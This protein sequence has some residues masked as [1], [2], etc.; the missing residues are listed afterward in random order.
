[1]INYG[2]HFIDK[3]DL[4]GVISVLKSDHLTQGKRIDLFEKKLIKKFKCDY[5][6][7]VS[8]GTAAL[9]LSSLALKWKKGDTVICS[10]ITF[11]A[12]ANCILYSAARPLFVDIDIKNF[13]IDLNKIELILKKKKRIKAIIATD[14]AGNPCDWKNL[15]YL[16]RKY[17]FKLVNDNCHAI[18]AKYYGRIDYATQFSDLVCHSYH[19]VKSITTGEG[20]AVLSNNQE[21]ITKIKIL[22]THG[23]LKNFERTKTPWLSKMVE[24]GYNYRLSDISAS[25]GITQLEKIEKFLN[26]RK[27]IA[28]IYFKELKNIC[29]IQ[30]QEI[31]KQNEHAF[32]LFPVLINFKKIKKTR[33]DMFKYFLKNGIVLQVHYLPIYSHFFYKKKF[34][35]MKKD[36]PNSE[37]F[38]NE[39][40]SLPIF[41]TLKEIEVYKIVRLL[42]NF[43]YK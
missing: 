32:H 35:I 15:N 5:S 12:A 9:H 29:E 8:S 42:K 14:F 39:E 40:V 27:R 25:L 23:I 7:V 6:A 24:L 21:L 28:N 1:M 22:R 33:S 2:K 37:K 4:N 26:K 34:N 41:Y 13:N 30:F 19:P 20:G 16:S 18:G 11:V 17:D 3:K 43:I 31:E 38:Y 10:P 36:F